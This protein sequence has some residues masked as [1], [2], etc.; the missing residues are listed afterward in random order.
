MAVGAG[1]DESQA[2]KASM[3][4]MNRMLARTRMNIILL[5]AIWND[6]TNRWILYMKMSGP[7]R[8]AHLDLQDHRASKWTNPAGY[9]LIPLAS[10]LI[11]YSLHNLDIR[12]GGIKFYV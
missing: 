9:N 5:L 7:F 12:R 10:I 3:K 6:T 11:E 4:T 2:T 1:V 8:P